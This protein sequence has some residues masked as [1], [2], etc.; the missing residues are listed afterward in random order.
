VYLVP[1]KVRVSVQAN[2]GRSGSRSQSPPD[3]LAPALRAGSV[4]AI[5]RTPASSFDGPTVGLR[6]VISPSAPQRR[7]GLE[8]SSDVVGHRRPFD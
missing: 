7:R 2:A 4:V 8:S 1:T 6:Y 5:T 3:T